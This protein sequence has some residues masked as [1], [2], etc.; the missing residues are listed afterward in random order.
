WR[1]DA[2]IAG[3]GALIEHS[4]HDLDLLRFLLG[5]VADVSGRTANFAGHEGIEDVAV[6]TLAFASGATAGLVS[7]WHGV[8]SRPSTRRLEVFCERGMAWTDDDYTGPL[9]VETSDGAEARACPAPAWVEELPVDRRWRS[10]AGQYAPANRSFLEALARG[11]PPEPGLDVA[12]VVGTGGGNAGPNA[13]LRQVAAPNMAGTADGAVGV[14]VP[15]SEDEQKVLSEIER[16]FYESD[17]AF[18][19]EVGSTT[20]YS[21]AGRNLKW[22]G[23][24]F[25]AGLVI[26][27]VSFASSIFLGVSGFVVMLGSAVVFERNLRKMGKA[28]WHSVSRSMRAGGLRTY[29]SDAGRRVRDRFRKNQG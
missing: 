19:R 20:L 25:V 5:E 12:L 9:H 29:F 26:M 22:A 13:L 1:A 27:L 17:P 2:A 7:V 24:G 16:Q 10:F 18:A 6:A 11:R 28:G 21:H 15:L 14:E 3:G 23:L 8:L 4:I